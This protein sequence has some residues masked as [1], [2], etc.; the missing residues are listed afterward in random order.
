MIDKY[1]DIIDLPHHQSKI[2]PQ[3]SI[4]DRAAQFSSFQA[5]TGFEDKIKETNRLTDKFVPP[6]ESEMAELDNKLLLLS[7]KLSLNPVV[8]ITYF[9]PDK[10]KDGGAYVSVQG[11][12]KK[13]DKVNKFLT[14]DKDFRIEFSTITDIKIKNEEELI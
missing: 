12:L 3:M 9:V 8:T 14:L 4:N 6:S 2:Y 11:T 5:L 7:A 13:I 1:R 10:K